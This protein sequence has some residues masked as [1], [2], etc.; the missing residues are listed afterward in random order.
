MAKRTAA[1]K[2]V[3]EISGALPHLIRL[4]TGRAWID[5][6]QEA[7]VL[8]ISL[9]RPQ[10]ATDTEYLEDEGILLRYRGKE[11]VGV[12]VLGA[13]KRGKKGKARQRNS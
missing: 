12:T 9:K 10:K 2:T 6:D 11:L 3:E 4:P 1:A 5:Y 8:Y 13:S 7:D